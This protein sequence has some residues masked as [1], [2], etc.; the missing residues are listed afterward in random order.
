MV[1]KHLKK[2]W[3]SYRK[4]FFELSKGVFVEYGTIIVLLMVFAYTFFIGY[5]GLALEENAETGYIIQSLGEENYTLLMLSAGILILVYLVF[6]VLQGGFV[7]MCYE[8]LRGK[9]KLSTMFKTS[10]KKAPSLMGSSLLISIVLFLVFVILVSF[11]YTMNIL[12]SILNTVP[13][14]VFVLF[15]SPISILF[16]FF[17]QGIVIDNL[18][19]IKSIQKSMAFS[20]NNYIQTFSLFIIFFILLKIVD[21]SFGA[22]PY[23]DLVGL[24]ISYFVIL[25]V[26]VLSFTNLYITRKKRRK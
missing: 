10:R 20:Q 8:S 17:V 26:M 18:G 7:R 13:I 4:N 14:D 25:P 24:L 9:T 6:A 23:L 22:V 3:S 11:L 5:L 1:S 19:A 15:M 16:Y 2:A 12:T 21:Y